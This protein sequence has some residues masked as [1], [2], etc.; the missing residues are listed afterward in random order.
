[1]A[2]SIAALLGIVLA[3]MLPLAAASEEAQDKEAIYVSMHPH[4][5]TNLAGGRQFVQ[6]KAQALVNNEDTQQALQLHMPAVR[7]ALLMHLGELRPEELRSVQQKQKF[8]DDAV[9][10]MREVLDKYAAGV[11]AGVEGMF[12][13][14]M[15][16][17]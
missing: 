14:S 3:S 11:G 6:M 2:R 4:L 1:M 10:I 13:T 12:I 16:I 15:V 7:H 9:A 8:L 17:Q 5:L